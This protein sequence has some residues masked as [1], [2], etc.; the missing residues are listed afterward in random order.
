[1]LQLQSPLQGTCAFV[2]ILKFYDQTY[3]FMLSLSLDIGE[4]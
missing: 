3:F 1:M 2:L 4:R